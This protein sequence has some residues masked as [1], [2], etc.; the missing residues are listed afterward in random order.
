MT[1][2]A[3]RTVELNGLAFHCRD[4]GGNGR[5]VLLLH[6]LASTAHIWD[7]VAPLL[8]KRHRVLAL[9]Q[10]GHGLSAKPDDGY[11]YAT[12]ASDAL[13]FLDH[14]GAPSAI[15]VGHSW[16]A[17]VAIELAASY[18]LRTEAI[19]LVDGGISGR[20]PRSNGTWEDYAQAMAPPELTHLTARAFIAGARQRWAQLRSWTPELETVLMSL[21]D[22]TQEGTIR[23][24]F[25]R[26]QHM[27]VVRAMW[28]NRGANTLSAVS[29]PVL[30]M[31]CRRPGNDERSQELLRRREEALAALAASMPTLTVRWLEDSVH[32]VPL[33]R[34]ELVADTLAAFL[35]TNPTPHAAG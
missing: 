11:D 16:G 1:A 26:A 3:D 34:P 7:F 22:V 25:P 33:Q 18:P 6:G 28:E 9:D 23:P 14:L 24:R 20:G 13:A 32:D 21:F 2:V 10:R 17:S 4:W 8:A 12:V 27:Q 29:C 5:L 35:E 31:P 19:A 30:A 15:V